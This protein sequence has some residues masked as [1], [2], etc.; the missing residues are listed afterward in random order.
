[1][2]M[3]LQYEGVSNFDFKIE[4]SISRDEDIHEIFGAYRTV[5]A[6]PMENRVDF[7]PVKLEK[8]GMPIFPCWKNLSPSKIFHVDEITD[9]IV[10]ELAE[11]VEKREITTKIGQWL[12]RAAFE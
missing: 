8:V 4:K 2:K 11:S 7:V 12:S 3:F 5:V 10:R 6:L 9:E 1:M